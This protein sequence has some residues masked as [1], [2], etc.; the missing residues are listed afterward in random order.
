MTRGGKREGSGR[1]KGTTKKDIA[2]NRTIRLA[3]NDY[4]KFLNLG[5]AR[6]LKEILEQI[7]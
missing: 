2:K 7:K 5:G 1:P 3:D 6:W 4:K